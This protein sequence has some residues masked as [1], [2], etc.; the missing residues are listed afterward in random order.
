MDNT[1]I[2]FGMVL[3]IML[4]LLLDTYWKSSRSEQR[5]VKWLYTVVA[6]GIG[7]FGAFLLLAVK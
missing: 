3:I 7:A 4:L 1:K 5:A 6:I 2:I